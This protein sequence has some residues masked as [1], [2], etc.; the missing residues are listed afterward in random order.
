MIEFKVL[1]KDKIEDLYIRHINDVMVSDYNRMYE[2]V[3]CFFNPN[4]NIFIG[5]RKV[6]SKSFIILNL[7]DYESISN[8][9]LLK[10]GTLL[11]EYIFEEINSKI[12]ESNLENE[13][14]ENLY[15]KLEIVLKDKTVNYDFDLKIDIHKLISNFVNISMELNMSNYVD[16]V[17]KLIYYTK[18][19]AI[20]RNIIILCNSLIFKDVFDDIDDI[21]LFKFYSNKFPNIIIG[22]E[23]VNSDKE[24]IRNQ[25]RL[26]L[27]TVISDIEIDKYLDNFCFEYKNTI[28]VNDY[29]KY[30][31]Y[32]IIKN[33]LNLKFDI[34]LDLC[35]FENQQIYKEYINSLKEC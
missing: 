25:V 26:N 20:R 24:I 1:L 6:D 19:N 15:S 28:I 27:P 29:K 33:V 34:K 2:F 16:I 9:L 4:S 11:Y 23:I 18:A 7:L 3:S 5:N 21:Y 10:K 12:E 8:Q 30:A 14:E 17:K 13:I 32:L 31:I 35:N 22:N